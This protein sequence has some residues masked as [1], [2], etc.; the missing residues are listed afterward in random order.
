MKAMIRRWIPSPLGVQTSADNRWN[1]ALHGS[2]RLI[3]ALT[4]MPTRSGVTVEVLRV[5][6]TRT[7]KEYD[8]H[9]K[10]FSKPVIRW[11]D[12]LSKVHV[13]LRLA[14]ANL[15]WR[16]IAALMWH[17]VKV[18]TKHQQTPARALIQKMAPPPMRPE[19]DERTVY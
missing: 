6:G 16:E 15:S 12:N 14:S 4:A 8:G 10:D 18:L 2:I 19:I 3:N 13:G 1:T 17:P 11:H 7:A 5:I 9:R